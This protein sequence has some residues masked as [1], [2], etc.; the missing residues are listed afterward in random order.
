MAS[1]NAPGDPPGKRAAKSKAAKSGAPSKASG[2]KR[3][4]EAAKQRILQAALAEFSAKGLGGARVDVIAQRAGANKRMLYHYFGNKDDLFLLVLERAYEDIRRHEDALH[5]GEH[6]PV[7]AMAELVQFTFDFMVE[8]PHW[9]NL[10]NSENLH[11]ARHLK[12]SKR[13]REMHSP[14]VDTIKRVLRKGETAGV[15]RQG[16]DPV[17]LYISIAALSYFYFSNI[18]TLSTIFDRDL[19]DPAERDIRRRHAVEVVLGYLKP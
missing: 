9:I 13:I 19:A 8:H 5:L 4:P 6:E 10:L 2:V 11:R 12:R 15:F 18:H 7:A 14:L 17:Q 3:D 16:V 1:V